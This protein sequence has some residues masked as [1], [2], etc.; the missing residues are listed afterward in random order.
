M[1]QRPFTDAQIDAAVQA[2][3]DPDRFEQAQDVVGRAA[4]QLQKVLGLAL[5]S[6]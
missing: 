3:S 4:P 5:Q 1:P 6:L 2:L